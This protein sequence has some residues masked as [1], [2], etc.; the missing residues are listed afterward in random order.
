[1]KFMQNECGQRDITNRI[2]ILT[3]RG[4]DKIHD[5]ILKIYHKYPS[6]TILKHA[7]VLAEVNKLPQGSLLNM[8]SHD[9]Y[10]IPIHVRT[11]ILADISHEQKELNADNQINR[12]KNKMRP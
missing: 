12:R 3:K 5:V 11:T 2:K 1:M 9:S 7:N 10:S 6:N 4:S 8:P